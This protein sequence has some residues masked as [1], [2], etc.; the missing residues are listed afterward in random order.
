MFSHSKQDDV[1]HVCV[2]KDTNVFL[3]T[4][5]AQYNP[6]LAEQVNVMVQTRTRTNP[7]LLC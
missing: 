3:T 6:S 4:E 1:Q 7:V 5:H 2:C